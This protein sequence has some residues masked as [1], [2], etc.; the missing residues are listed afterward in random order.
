MSTKV[1]TV[2]MVVMFAGAVLAAQVAPAAITHDYL[3]DNSSDRGQDTGT[4]DPSPPLYAVPLSTVGATYDAV[5]TGMS[6]DQGHQAL[7]DAKQEWIGKTFGTGYISM[8]TLGMLDAFTVEAILKVSTINATANKNGQQAIF[9]C[10]RHGDTGN[11]GFTFVIDEG[12]LIFNSLHPIG[13]TPAVGGGKATIPTTGDNAWSAD[14]W[15]HV[16]FTYDGTPGTSQ[17]HEQLY[18]TKLDTTVPGSNPTAN[19]LSMNSTMWMKADMTSE[20]AGTPTIGNYQYNG[21][22]NNM[23]GNMP[24][25]GYIDRVR[26]HNV[27]LGAGDFNLPNPIPEPSS[28]VLLLAGGLL[29]A[30]W[31][32]R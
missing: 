29:L 22:T 20:M 5:L 10:D 7:I 15:F 21:D 17:G 19:A 24:L 8:S 11:R 31:R 26:I 4:H 32:R 3:F 12:E 14:D 25:L 23:D 2:L 28:L 27:A 9:A 13:G 1:S 18:W 30:L 16:A 6:P